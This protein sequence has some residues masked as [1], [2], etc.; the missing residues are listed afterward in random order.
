MTF[1]DAQRDMRHAYFGGA[2]GLFCSGAIWLIAG[3]VAMT[4]ETQYALWALFG[5]GMFIHPLSVLVSKL[6]GR[7]GAA[8][9]GNPLNTLAIAGTFWML[10]SF[11]LAFAIAVMR[12]ELFFPAM[13]LI[14]GGRYLTFTTV[15]GN[16]M[17]WVVGLALAFAAMGVVALGLPV[18]M[19]ALAGGVIEILFGVVVMMQERRQP[20]T[21]VASA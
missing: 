8:T 9:K 14:I 18:G 17:Y 19:G 5:G 12:I 6:L 4:Q 3:V 11:P 2:S 7:P 10:L 13:L 1:S 20:A 15:Y 16:N 21:A